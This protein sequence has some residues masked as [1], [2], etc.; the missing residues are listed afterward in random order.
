MKKATKPRFVSHYLVLADLLAGKDVRMYSDTVFYL[1]ARIENI[2]LDLVK[3][4]LEFI[5][6][7]KKETSYS[8][9]KP[10]I[11]VPSDENIKKA[12]ELMARYGTKEV[13]DFLD[14]SKR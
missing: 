12:K 4:G 13:L 5:E 10:Y 1:A 7:I 6:D 2:K 8:Y 14:N 9:Y 11:L 3:Q